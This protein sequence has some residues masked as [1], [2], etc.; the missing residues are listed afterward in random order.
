M[1]GDAQLEDARAGAAHRHFGLC[2]ATIKMVIVLAPGIL[3]SDIRCLLRM[4]P[5]PVGEAP[6]VGWSSH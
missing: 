1:S 6:R 3:A 5:F 2:P 4:L